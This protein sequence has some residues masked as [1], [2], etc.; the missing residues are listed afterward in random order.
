MSFVAWG[1]QQVFATLALVRAGEADITGPVVPHIINQP[2][3]LRWH[4]QD[5]RT[6][7]EID[8]EPGVGRVVGRGQFQGPGVHH[9]FKDRHGRIGRPYF[10]DSLAVGPLVHYRQAE[11]ISLH[12]P[13]KV[14]VVIKL[15]GAGLVRDAIEEIEGA[16]AGLN[17]VRAGDARRYG[18]GHL[19]LGCR[20]RWCTGCLLPVAGADSDRHEDKNKR[21]DPELVPWSH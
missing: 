16:D 6:L 2:N 3:Y 9:G 11:Q 4:L 7:T 14:Q 17:L 20:G 13:L 1:Q 8:P 19:I 15:L 21:A 18:G 12:R 5:L 10:E